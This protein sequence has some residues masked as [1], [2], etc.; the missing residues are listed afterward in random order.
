MT[1]RPYAAVATAACILAL[2]AGIAAVVQRDDSSGPPDAAVLGQSVRRT[3]TTRVA[4]AVTTTAAP[5]ET[6]TTTIPPAPSTSTT[7]DVPP[8]AVR[9]TTTVAVRQVV[10][11]ADNTST[12]DY[13]ADGGSATNV[14][15]AAGDQDPF[16]FNA[17]GS[18]VDH[19]GVAELRADMTNQTDGEVFFPGGLV[20]HFV[21]S[22]DGQV[23]RT[24]E[25]RFPDQL[26]LPARGSVEIESATSLDEHG[27]Y[28]VVAD[29]TVEYR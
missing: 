2:L 12:F 10:E 19:D 9:T 15:A 8:A 18:D 3:S 11:H 14:P 28:G 1:R 27:H 25:L 4:V 5:T 17:Y 20:L 21:M 7:I 24:V 29:T 26:S 16:L 23:W 6:T 22:R 13:L